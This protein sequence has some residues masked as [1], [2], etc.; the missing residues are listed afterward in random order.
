MKNWSFGKIL[1]VAG[2]GFVAFILVVVV[3]INTFAG[4]KSAQAPTRA[5]ATAPVDATRPTT[6]QVVP[7]RAQA[8][9]AQ[10]QIVGPDI[11]SVQLEG[12]QQA[13]RE[14]K[15]ATQALEQKLAQALAKRDETATKQTQLLMGEIQALGK[16]IRA[17]EEDRLLATEVQVIRPGANGDGKQDQTSQT[18][19]STAQYS[20]PAGF[21]VRA[22][23]GNR[24]WLS[25]G[26]R[27]FS[28]LKGQQPP[29][30]ATQPAKEKPAHKP[31]IS[32]AFEQ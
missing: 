1:A 18:S 31:T 16:R 11:V 7:A 10:A 24:V 27:E 19:A 6:G 14:A 4:K 28:I 8:A 12:A 30:K 29:K 3:A 17:L 20:P 21:V 23:L 15:E 26:N 2:G 13:L 22:E 32:A 25:D 9:S 5:Q